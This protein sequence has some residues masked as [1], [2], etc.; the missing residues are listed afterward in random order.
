MNRAPN[1]KSE[2]AETAPRGTEQSP[3]KRASLI[4][5]CILVTAIFLTTL[6]ILASLLL[7]TQTGNALLWR[8]LSNSLPALAGE[9]TEGQLMTGWNI[10]N[11]Q[12]QDSQVTFQ[13]D[14]IT[15]K[16]QL[17]K[18][19][20]RQL[21]VQL[22]EVKG[23][24]LEIQPAAE[25]TNPS[26]PPTADTTINIP[27]D[28]LINQIHIQNFSVTVPGTKISLETFTANAHL[29]DSQ[30]LIPEALADNLQILL[31]NQESATP[32]SK[33]STLK[34]QTSAGVDLSTITLPEIKLPIPISLENFTLTNARYQQGDIDETLKE[35]KLSFNWQA[36]HITNLKLKAEQTRANILLNGE[37]QLSENYPLTMNLDATILDDFNIPELTAIKGDKLSLEA[38]GDLTKLQLL[39]STEGSINTTLEGNIGP[40]APNFP[41]NLALKWP[42]LQW[43]LQGKLPEFS[44]SNGVARITGN[45]NQYQLSLD[46]A[47]K[48]ADQPATQM[49]LDASGSLEQ[50]N[51]KTLSLN[52]ADERNLSEKPLILTGNVSWKDGVNWQGH[53]L[54]SKLKPELWLRDLPGVLS[55]KINTQFIMRDGSWQLSIPE[56]NIN[57]SLQNNA[58]ELKG[59]LEADNRAR[60]VA[61]LPLKVNIQNLYAALGDNRLSISGQ[62]AEQL[63]LTAKLDANTL[64]VISPELNGSIKGSVKL[65]GSDE[66]PKL[67]FSFD[68]P[69]INVQQASFRQLNV[70]G[71]LT[72]ATLL[73]GNITVEAGSLNSGSIQLKQLQLNA[74]GSERKHQISFKSQG[75]PL[76]GELLIKGGWQGAHGNNN[77]KWQG[78]LASAS[79]ASPVDNWSLEK[80]V[81]ILLNPTN[82]VRLTEQCWLAKPARLCIDASTFSA[83]QGATRFQLS[84]FNLSNLKPFLPENL[85]WQA[86]L[87]GS[88]DIQWNNDHPTAHIQLQTTPGEVTS[89]SENPVSVKYQKLSTVIN[90]NEDDLKAEFNFD[91]KQLGTAHINLAIDNIQSDQKLSGQARLQDMRLYF[92]QPLIP[93]ISN[94]DGVL[95]ADTRMSGTLKE[96]LL[97]GNLKLSE[98]QLAAKQEM[99]KVS[100]LITELNV[101]GNKGDISG[102]MKVGDGEMQLSGNLDWQQMP[103]SGVIE[104]KG[105]DLG[106][107]VPGI[108]QLRASPNLKLTMG[109]AQTLTGN[110]TIPWARVRI[111]QLPKQAVTPSDDVV[112]ITPGTRETLLHA[113]PPFSM[114]VNVVLGKDIKID[115][116]GL[117]SDLGGHLL[118]D[119]QPGKPMVADGSIQLINGRYHQFGQDLLIKEG[120]IIF[121]GPLS[122]PYLAVNAIRNPESIEDDVSVGIQVSGPPSRP[123]FSI[124]S[125]PSMS[126]QE[127]WSYLLRGRGLEDGDSSA[128]QS[129]LI[130]F[131]VSQFGGVVTSIG[132]KIGLSDVTLD[133]QGSGDD[134]QVTIGGTIAPGLRVQ[135]GAG[136]F[137]S[138]AEV[139]V[140]YELMPRL[141]LQAISGVAQAIDLFY[142]FKIETGKK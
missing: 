98:G 87:S 81:N 1:R 96:P 51:I 88:G 48:V 40:F 10:K 37:I 70:N 7:F 106:G 69:S 71:E 21:P 23:G 50:L 102:S 43:P 9:L 82:E 22:V 128:V 62:I 84:D 26:E 126:Q 110:I 13:A 112:I 36:T 5:R 135:Y 65:S 47:M 124:Y 119:L 56:L 115:A 53:I 2:D 31:T 45:L 80:P 129:M 108:L 60:S 64:D 72:K 66:H 12:W 63:S 95:S 100:S 54:L 76:S 41:L 104:I 28:I 67:L 94:I 6:V 49:S 42:K 79:I 116:Y 24:N 132:E 117:K 61:L 17:A 127:Q 139:K 120:N 27:L 44:T 29:L 38:S 113:A 11:F 46:A 33:T 16:W 74:S 35:L 14:E 55:G 15:L 30:L 99:V 141:Y 19:L 133:T 123:E 138:I 73:E 83:S 137:N 52:P 25:E 122:S 134:T 20:T 92:L 101:D 125:D 68:S 78:Q 142:Q 93:D 140:R 130:G 8:Q 32:T 136:V 75:E 77:A 105:Q 109:E 114:D 18:L 39:L 57:G 131:G 111:K 89:N 34:K 58:L 118:L 85:N 97:F 90:L 4:K 59:R 107:K 3:V 91:S 121:S 86:I 103:P